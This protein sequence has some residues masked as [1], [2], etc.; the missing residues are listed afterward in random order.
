[1]NKLTRLLDLIYPRICVACR[2][3]LG[4]IDTPICLNCIIDLP[5]IINDTV[6]QRKIIQKF[7]GKVNITDAKS[8]L[9]FEKGNVAQ[10]LMHGLKYRNKK[11]IGVWLG[12]KFAEA[13]LSMGEQDRIDLIMPIPM[14]ETKQKQRGYNQA[15]LIAEGMA[16]V[17]NVP[18]I[19][20]GLVKTENTS[21]QT[22]KNRYQRYKNTS[23]IFQVNTEIKLIGKRVCLVDDV[24]TTGATLEAAAIALLEYDCEVSVKTIASAF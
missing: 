20:N 12:K 3:P 14:H 10:Y 11:S 8:Y 23:G 21:S 2:K 17:L 4:E 7:D 5:V 15:E 19:N 6:Q 22:K 16:S 24:L 18:I 9:L 13:L 1:M